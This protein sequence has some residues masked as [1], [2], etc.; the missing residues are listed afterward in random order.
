MRSKIEMKRK[1]PNKTFWTFNNT[2]SRFGRNYLNGNEWCGNT[3]II[4]K[5]FLCKLVHRK[6]SAHTSLHKDLFFCSSTIFLLLFDVSIEVGDSCMHRIVLTIAFE[7]ICY[8]CNFGFVYLLGET[9]LSTLIHF[10]SYQH[11]C[12]YWFHSK[13]ERKNVGF[14]WSSDLGGINPYALVFVYVGA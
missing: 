7:I 3:I 8:E 9:V 13:I 6:Q 14:F 4:K 5:L 1:R 10:F 11:S 2:L 12:R